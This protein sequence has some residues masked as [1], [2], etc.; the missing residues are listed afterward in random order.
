MTVQSLRATWDAPIFPELD[1]AKC[2]LSARVCAEL[3]GSK[4]H[5]TEELMQQYLERQAS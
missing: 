5:M 4:G 2:C 3:A 1:A